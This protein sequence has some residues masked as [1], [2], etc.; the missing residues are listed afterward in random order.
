[1]SAGNGTRLLGQDNDN[2][3]DGNQYA[4]ADVVRSTCSYPHPRSPYQQKDTSPAENYE[5]RRG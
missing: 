5:A 1:M 2:H 3:Y 4:Q